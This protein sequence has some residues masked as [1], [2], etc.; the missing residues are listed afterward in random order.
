M[1]PYQAAE[2][3]Q[4]R[5]SFNDDGE[6]VECLVKY[7]SDVLGSDWASASVNT[8]NASD[9]YELVRAKAEKKYGVLPF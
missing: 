2:Q 6:V 4:A 7:M 8:L 5:F 3:I 1:T 9:Y